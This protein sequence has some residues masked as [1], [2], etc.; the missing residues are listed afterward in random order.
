[1]NTLNPQQS[2]AYAHAQAALQPV[3][4]SFQVDESI[5]SLIEVV[6]FHYETA[7]VLMRRLEPVTG[8]VLVGDA[9]LAGGADKVPLALRIDAQRDQIAVLTHSLQATIRALQI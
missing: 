3:A 8:A 6:E 2:R 9:C 5:A 7:L 1:M 4:E